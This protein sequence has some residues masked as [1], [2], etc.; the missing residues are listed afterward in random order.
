[1]VSC[2]SRYSRIGA[3]TSSYSRRHLPAGLLAAWYSLWCTR[4]PR[5]KLGQ[6]GGVSEDHKLSPVAGVEL[7]H[8]TAHVRL[9]GQGAEH[10]PAGDLLV[11]QPGGDKRHNL[12]LAGRQRG[13][14]GQRRRRCRRWLAGRLDAVNALINA[15]VTLG[16]SS[17]SPPA[18][19]RIACSNSSGSR[20][21]IRKPL[22]PALSAAKTFSSSSNVVSTTILMLSSSWSATIRLVA[23]SPST[24]GILRSIS[25]TSGLC[26]R[27]SATAIPPLDASATTSM[28]AADSSRARKPARRS[29]WSSASSTRITAAPRLE[30]VAAARSPRSRQRPSV[31]R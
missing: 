13:N 3:A 16:A 17:A 2:R 30:Q 5:R 26:W 28:S 25:T 6:A 12:A 22:A 19:T 9:G 23:V 18:T 11:R 15:R 14:R 27:A 24:S 4:N 31:L 1:M 7:D 21:L 8:G 20:S 10:E 29:A